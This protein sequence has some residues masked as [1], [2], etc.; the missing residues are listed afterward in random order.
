MC[1]DR[2]AD[3]LSLGE[4]GAARG[5][6]VNENSEER[7]GQIWLERGIASARAGRRAEARQALFRALNYES[8]REMCW[9]WLAAVSEDTQQER[10]Y[11]NKVLALNPNNRFA[12]AGL[13]HLDA[14]PVESGKP[15]QPAGAGALG[16]L[17]AAPASDEERNTAAPA[18]QP[19]PS[20][21]PTDGNP[22]DR[23]D[24]PQET[25]APVVQVTAQDATPAR[26]E[27]PAVARDVQ[28]LRRR[29]TK[30]P[31]D[32]Q[33]VVPAT[34]SSEARPSA[35]PTG[36]QIDEPSGWTVG[37][38]PVTA[39]EQRRDAGADA[40]DKAVA[41]PSGW[42]RSIPKT[43]SR[44]LGRA[45]AAPQPRPARYEVNPP[46]QENPIRSTGG[47][48]GALSEVFQSHETW[49]AMAATVS[50][51]GLAFILIVL[52]VMSVLR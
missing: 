17:E 32:E 4:R 11:L 42:T 45:V 48:S 10:V 15:G 49:T 7:D 30:T 5:R 1:L 36:D 29:R 33:R 47:F 14:Q 9:L 38:K 16:L 24:R 31:M 39:H 34:V 44:G 3:I 27:Q 50:L 23:A 13:A 20:K 43:E 35:G 40:A 21:G 2:K 37:R 41:E 52:A 51:A 8:Q 18:P 22:P 12:R 28:P 25:P 19:E 6:P 26:A 46:Q